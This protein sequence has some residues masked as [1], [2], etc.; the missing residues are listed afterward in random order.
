MKKRKSPKQ[1]IGDLRSG[2]NEDLLRLNYELNSALTT[3]VSKP[4]THQLV[5]KPFIAYL[6]DHLVWNK[7]NLIYVFMGKKAQDFA[8]LIP[9]NNYKIMVSHPASAGYNGDAEWDCNDMWNKINKYLEQ[10]GQQRISW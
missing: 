2:I 7:P 5:W 6:L 3:T 4:G 9:D 10:N 8:D 1:E